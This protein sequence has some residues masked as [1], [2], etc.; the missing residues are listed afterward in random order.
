MPTNFGCDQIIS[1]QPAESNEVGSA[2]P[3]ALT[4]SVGHLSLDP[5]NL[6]VKGILAGL[7]NTDP[8]SSYYTAD[9]SVAEALE[10]QIVSGVARRMEI[11]FSCW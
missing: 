7:S 2:L 9:G 10:L 5:E 6:E 3:F 4:L 1:S 8:P 11:H